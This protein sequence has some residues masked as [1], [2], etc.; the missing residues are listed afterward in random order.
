MVNGPFTLT[1]G[2]LTAPGLIGAASNRAPVKFGRRQIETASSQICRVE[3]RSRQIGRSSNRARVKS[4]SRQI[5]GASNRAPVKS[6]ARQIGEASSRPGGLKR[7]GVQS[8]CQGAPERACAALRLPGRTPGRNGLKRALAP[9]SNLSRGRVKPNR[10]EKAVFR[11]VERPGAGG[12]TAGPLESRNPST[13]RKTSQDGRLS[14]TI[15]TICDSAGIFVSHET[16][17]R[18]S[19]A[20]LAPRRISVSG[21]VNAGHNKA[22][23]GR[24]GISG[25]SHVCRNGRSGLLL[26]SLRFFA[27][28]GRFGVTIAVVRCSNAPDLSGSRRG[29][30]E[31]RFPKLL[32]SLRFLGWAST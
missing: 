31:S 14:V 1:A 17:R 25:R 4:R 12:A 3:A 30:T 28:A 29:E 13:G 19:P 26:I 5:R 21:C 18:A 8:G 10:V 11:A 7:A 27:G 2:G 9:L 6:I 32:G 24:N 20:I 16:R 22:G 15:P 23:L